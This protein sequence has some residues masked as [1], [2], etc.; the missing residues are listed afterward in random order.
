MQ[1]SSLCC[2]VIEGRFALH[3][4]LQIQLEW[5]LYVGMDTEGRAATKIL[6][7]KHFQMIGNFIAYVFTNSIKSSAEWK[8]N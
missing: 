5:T 4:T 1:L 8:P 7:F 6:Q 2:D 3:Q